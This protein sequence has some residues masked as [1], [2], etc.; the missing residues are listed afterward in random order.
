MNGSKHA[1]DP[2]NL[3]FGAFPK[4]RDR[5]AVRSRVR[6]AHCPSFLEYCQARRR[7]GARWKQ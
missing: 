4:F 6:P 3:G 1:D 2:V 7:H 5:V